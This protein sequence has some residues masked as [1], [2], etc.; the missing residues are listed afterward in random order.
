M[1]PVDE[2]TW[3]VPRVTL[4]ETPRAPRWPL[5]R[6]RMVSW[7]PACSGSV[8]LISMTQ[9]SE[10][11][12]AGVNPLGMRTVSDGKGFEVSRSEVQTSD[13]DLQTNSPRSETTRSAPAF[14]KA[15]A[16]P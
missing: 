6:A 11:K 5:L 15:S 10:P 9:G 13:F 3:L 8:P 12:S 14:F 2:H 7:K 1:K 4:F 16:S